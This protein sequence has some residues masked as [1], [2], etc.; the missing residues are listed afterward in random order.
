[1]LRV[2]AGRVSQVKKWADRIE[3]SRR[4]K[5][6]IQFLCMFAISIAGGLFAH[7]MGLGGVSGG[8]ILAGVAVVTV[9][10]AL[11]ARVDRD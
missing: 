3:L 1:M 6:G 2:A 11:N 10:P 8:A 7:V 5:Y 4:E 9:L